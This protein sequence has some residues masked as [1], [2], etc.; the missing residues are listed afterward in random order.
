MKT[1]TFTLK[2]NN[3][4]LM[5]NGRMA[6]PDEEQALEYTLHVQKK[7]NPRS[8]KFKENFEE[9]KLEW[10]REERRIQ[11]FGLVYWN[12]ALG[13][14]IPCDNILYMVREAFFG[15]GSTAKGAA[16]LLSILETDREAYPLEYSGPRTRAE[17]WN[18]ELYRTG[19]VR[20]EA[21]GGARVPVLQPL[22]KDWSLTFEL[23]WRDD[24]PLENL[25]G[26]GRDFSAEY[27]TEML[28]IQGKTFGIGAYRKSGNYGNFDLLYD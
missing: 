26:R 20:N 1:K 16:K 5:S 17:R 25:L 4:L 15:Y 10:M 18:A 6:N 19:M 3:T 12:A 23:K 14:H 28:C 8:K 24:V 2:G 27:L 13:F 11:F 22:F 9:A 7:P 21:L